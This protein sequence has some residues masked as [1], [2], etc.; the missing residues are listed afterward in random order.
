MVGFKWAPWSHLWRDVGFLIECGGH[1]DLRAPRWVP[2]FK[3]TQD[4]NVRVLRAVK[5]ACPA[6]TKAIYIYKYIYFSPQLREVCSQ[7]RLYGA[8]PLTD[9]GVEMERAV[10]E[11][12][13]S[14]RSWR[15]SGEGVVD[16]KSKPRERR[17][18]EVH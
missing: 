15:R 17:G 7:D 14:S 16:P 1:P 6:C 9:P 4:K 3:S 12:L 2:R 10:P 5:S 11:V 8:W 13:Y 18:A